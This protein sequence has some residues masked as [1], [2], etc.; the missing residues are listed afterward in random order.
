[1]LCRKVIVPNPK[2]P[3]LETYC[4]RDVGHK[5]KCSIFPTPNQCYLCKPMTEFRTIV[6]LQQHVRQVHRVWK[7]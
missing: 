4:M 7:G 3:R 6:E 1:M 5:G 2:E